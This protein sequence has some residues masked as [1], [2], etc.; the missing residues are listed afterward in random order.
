MIDERWG[1]FWGVPNEPDEEIAQRLVDNV[2]AAMDEGSSFIDMMYAAYIRE[3]QI[4]ADEAVLI[5]R[6]F[7]DGTR[8]YHYISRREMEEMMYS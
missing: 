4:P 3:T 2:D 6:T 7:P 8:T 1:K 5:Q